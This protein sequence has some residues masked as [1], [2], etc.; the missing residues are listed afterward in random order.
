MSQRDGKPLNCPPPRDPWTS[1]P[2]RF[3]R[4]P[5]GGGETTPSRS[6]KERETERK[7]ERE[8][9][10]ERGTTEVWQGDVSMG[11]V[12]NGTVWNEKEDRTTAE[13]NQ[14]KKNKDSFFLFFIFSAAFVGNSARFST[15]A[16]HCV[17]LLFRGL[18]KEQKKT[19]QKKLC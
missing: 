17:F 6:K 10:R 3:P 19:K 12:E 8:K 11:A 5:F 13:R 18:V 15:T 2:A 9:E 1:A 14:K 7:K 16:F 4:D